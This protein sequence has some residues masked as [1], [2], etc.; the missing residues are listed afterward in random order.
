MKISVIRCFL[1]GL[2]PALVLALGAT[3]TLGAPKA[4]QTYFLVAQPDLPDPMFQQ[5][6]ILMLPPTGT[7]LVVGL[8][9]N[10]PTKLKLSQLFSDSSGLKNRADTAFFGGPVDVGSP[11]VLVH[12][13]HAP[14][15]AVA[16]FK[17]VYLSMEAH[18]MS[19]LVKD[20]TGP[21]TVRLYLGR[22]QWTDDQLHNEMLE[23]SW[24]NVPSNPDF[25]FSADP[26]TVWRTLVAR[27][28]AIQ[29]SAPGTRSMGSFPMLL[30]IAWPSRPTSGLDE[31]P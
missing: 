18:G 24:Y 3:L 30:P 15:N 26:G 29:V 17:D 22:A 25:V 27:A 8:I 20:S 9:I 13:G 5:S 1:I 4:E 23:N 31:R 10:K 28:Q 2:V 11:L 12:T 7:P 19:D 6:V 14:G 16:L 21:Q